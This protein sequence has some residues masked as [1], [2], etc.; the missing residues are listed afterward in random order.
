MYNR[1][2][3]DYDYN[4]M[5][6]IIDGETMYI[7]YNKHYLGYLDKLNS[8]LE[9]SNYNYKYSKEELADKIDIF[10]IDKRGDILYNLGGVINHE[11]YFTSISNRGNIYPSGKLAEDIN[12][13]FGNY[14]N[15]KKEFKESANN[16]KG[17]GYTFLVKDKNN[18][19]LIINTSNQDTPYY[20]GLTPIMGI[21]LWEHAY[22]LQYK[23]NRSLY[24]DNYFKIVDF[25]KISARYLS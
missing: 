15:F 5:E 25:K 14:D 1:L 9:S 6:P 7:H 18:K 2:I 13:Y 23:N 8:L 11:I 22:Y 19:L 12:T 3:L 4:S 16:L 21:D 17:S 24:I 10:P 20:Y